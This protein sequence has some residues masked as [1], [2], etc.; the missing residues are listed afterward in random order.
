MILRVLLLTILLFLVFLLVRNFAVS[1]IRRKDRFARPPGPVKSE[2]LVQDP[3]CRRYIPESE[4][5]RAS[6][7][8]KTLYFC[9]REC[10]EKYKAGEKK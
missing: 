6:L 5:F 9:S 7:D 2:D 3:C 4:A 1:V 8:D 10:F